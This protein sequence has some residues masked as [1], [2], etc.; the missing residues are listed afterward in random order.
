M[1]M[2]HDNFLNASC[3]R[4]I[5]AE[6]IKLSSLG[7]LFLKMWEAG[8]LLK[9]P[10]WL[11]INLMAAQLNLSISPVL[12][13]ILEKSFYTRNRAERL[14]IHSCCSLASQANWEG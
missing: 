12:E 10:V 7:I 2:C 9:V 13:K 14:R 5:L 3:P 4:W 1:Q 8:E 11:R 6:T